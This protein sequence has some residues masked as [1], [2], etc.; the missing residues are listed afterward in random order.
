[1]LGS[2]LIPTVGSLAG[3]HSSKLHRLEQQRQQVARRL[4]ARTQHAATLRSRINILN[5]AINGLQI[6]INGLNRMIGRVR[7]DVR[8][9]QAHIDATQ[10]QIDKIK[11][12]ATAQAVMLYKTG[13]T[14]TL[15]MLLKSRSLTELDNKVELLGVAANQN[16]SA[17]VR[18]GRLQAQLVREHQSLFN[19]QAELRKERGA[20]QHSLEQRANLRDRVTHYLTTLNGKIRAAKDKER[21]LAGQEKQIRVV[22]AQAQAK[23]AVTVTGISSQGFIWPL[24]GPITSPFGPRWGSFHPGID[25]SGFTGEPFVAAKG[26]RVIYAS[27]M[28]GYGNATMVDVGGGV[29]TL[30]GHQSRLGVSVGQ[31]VQQ[32]QVIGYVGCTG[33]CTGPHLHFEVRVNG[34]AVDPMQFLP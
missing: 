14:Q 28:D 23:N 29:V 15:D 34:T 19:R 9:A 6:Q 20:Q 10:S 18:F 26:G 16:T 5:H 27:W 1:M 2:L 32:G 17:L 3:T 30:Y 12:L 25:I 21:G 11:H 22:I 7:S 24:N 31:T 13:G 4:A 8:T 33:L